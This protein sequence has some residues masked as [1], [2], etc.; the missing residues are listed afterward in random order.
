MTYRPNP[1]RCFSVCCRALIAFCLLAEA[2]AADEAR[3]RAR[4][5]TYRSQVV[6]LLKRYCVECHGKST[7]EAEINLEQ[8]GS[9]EN[10][11]EARTTW[12]KILQKVRSGEMPPKES[13]KPTKD[14]RD[15]LAGW[16]DGALNDIDCVKVADPGRV[17][18]RRLNRYEYRNTIRDLVGV[19]FEPATDFPGDDVGYGFDNIGDVLSLPTLLLEKYLAA[20]DDITH[21]AI[22]TSGLEAAVLPK[23]PA[24]SIKNTGGSP[25]GGGARMLAS[26]G[27][28][29]IEVEIPVAG[30]YELR[31]VAYGQQAGDEPTKMEFRFDGKGVETVEVKATQNKPQTYSRKGPAPAGKHKVSVAFV[32]DYYNP[33]APDPKDRDR[34]LVIQ[35]LAVIGPLGTQ[36]SDLPESHRRIFFVQPDQNSTPEQ[37]A[38]KILERFASRAYRRPATPQEIDRLTKLAALPREQGETF[39][40]GIR[41][42]M[43]AALVSPHFLFK[44]ELDPAPADNGVRLI[45]DYELATRLSYFLWSSMPDD[46]LL[47]DAWKGTLRK[48]GKLQA[49]VRRMLADPKSKAFVTNFALQWLQLRKLDD[50]HPD[51][52]RFPSFNDQLRNAMRQETELVF[53][54]IMREN[55]SVLELLTADYTFVNEAL[56]NHYG[57][58]GITGE[59][60]RQVSLQGFPRR[61]VITHA[62]VLAATSNPTRT[63]PVKRGRWILDNIIGEPPPPPVPDAPDLMEGEQAELSGSLRQRMEQHRANPTCASCHQRMDAL[64]FS[65]EN[66]DAVGGWRTKDGN[67]EIDAVGELPTGEK[68]TGAEEMIAVLTRTKT[69]AFARC[70]VEKALTYALGRGLEFYDKCAVDKIMDSLKQDDYRFA[71]M[72]MSIVESDPFQKRSGKRSTP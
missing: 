59:E 33:Q 29:G 65:L 13:A 5:E 53:G 72:V 11:L 34:N 63:S 8:Y 14:E 43:Q 19:D 44:V 45:S 24:A 60:F 47:V 55:R 49:H 28:V 58:S 27:E 51:P 25:Y 62:S 23:T 56:A 32:N 54:Q 21:R 48:D 66:F 12:N 3:E 15:L 68:F 61:G 20:A 70:L 2:V 67:F 41:L 46:E 18:I 4:A 35:S 7:A 71:T 9:V 1:M 22:V 40:E 36:R 38:R 64:G 6:P 17:T 69:D 50:F 42:A 39:E 31:V 37:A 57:I 10:I 52:K 26:S 30:E 16:V